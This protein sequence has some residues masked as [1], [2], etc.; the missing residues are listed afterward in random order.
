MQC[1]LIPKS[2]LIT[3]DLVMIHLEGIPLVDFLVVDLI[4]ISK[5]FLE[6]I[7]FLDSSEAE[8][9]EE[10]ADAGSEEVRISSSDIALIWQ[11]LFPAAMN[12]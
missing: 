12:Q 5:T 8:A 11:Q 4:S 9:A 7:S 3:I 1:S 6:E 2:E 10:A